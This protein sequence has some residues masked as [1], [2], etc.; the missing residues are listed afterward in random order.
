LNIAVTRNYGETAK[1]K[2]D[3]LLKHLF[4][5]TL[6]VTLLIAFALGWR[7]S[8]VVE[9]NAGMVEGVQLYCCDNLHNHL[10]TVLMNLER[11]DPGDVG[12]M[13]DVDHN[14]ATRTGLHCAP[15]VHKQLGTLEH[16]GGVRFSIGA[17]NT[18]SDIEAAI[19]AV[20]DV[21]KWALERGGKRCH[22]DHGL[23]KTQV[24]ATP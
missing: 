6:S 8:G 11:V 7:E 18:E 15:L 14:I 9:F 1:D 5:A 24:P 20:A 16:D 19:G 2:S 17:F 4:L 10:P 23:P 22:S 21:A 3:E 12:I 13:L